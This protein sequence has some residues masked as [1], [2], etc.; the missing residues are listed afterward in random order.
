M[1]RLVAPTGMT[2]KSPTASASEK[3]IVRPHIRPPI[4]SFSPS[5]SSSS[6]ALA[7]IA[8]ARKPIFSD[9]AS[10]T[11][12]RI[13]GQRR[14]RW[15]FAQETIGSEVTSISPS[16]LRTAT[17]QVETPRIITPSSTA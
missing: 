5:S 8:R 12:P 4:S 9:S 15:R 13:T 14:T 17:A 1:I 3:A 6:W 10:A 2:K 16:G 7:E 11:T